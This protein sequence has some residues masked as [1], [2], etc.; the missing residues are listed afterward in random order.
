MKVKCFD[1]NTEK[2]LEGKINAFLSPYPLFICSLLGFLAVA[3]A[4]DGK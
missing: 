2:D 3:P 4:E 1:E